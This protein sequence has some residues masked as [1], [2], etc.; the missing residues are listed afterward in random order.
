MQEKQ[1]LRKQYREARAALDAAERAKAD[2]AIALALWDTEEYRNAGTVYSFVS[3]G[4]DV[5]TIATFVKAW[6]DGKRV[7]V[8]TFNPADHSLNF[9]E[10]TNM[11]DL[12]GADESVDGSIS[13]VEPGP[14]DICIVPGLAYDVYGNRL[15]T[16]NGYFDRFLATF[17]GVAVGLAHDNQVSEEELPQQEHDVP[18]QLLITET[19]I[20]RRA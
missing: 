1:E 13:R 3:F 20:L 14:Q 2:T 19:R 5:D 16:G 18:V 7:A 11:N 12:H 9:Y 15:G 17:P 6:E 10:V 4:I 8:P